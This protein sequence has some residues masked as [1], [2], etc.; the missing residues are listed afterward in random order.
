MLKTY[1]V[2]LKYPMKVA[3]IEFPAGEQLAAITCE[4]SPHDL[5]GLVQH[6]HAIVEEITD[7]GFDES[8]DDVDD[9]AD[10][11]ISSNQVVSESDDIEAD[12]DADSQDELESEES[13]EDETE[14][15][16]TVLDATAK[17]NAVAAFVADGL[18]EKTATSLVVENGILGPDELRLK[19]SEAS[20]E[21]DDLEGIGPVR[22]KK[23]EAIYLK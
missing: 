5:L 8:E 2:T 13:S 12:S 23:I 15:Q 10:E 20:F 14:D 1:A 18:D 9:Q 17:A 7:Q 3:G 22:V 19:M 11:V 21:L 16:P 6:H 4:I